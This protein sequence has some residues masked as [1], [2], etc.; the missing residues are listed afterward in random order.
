[1]KIASWNVNSVKARLEHLLRWLK[2]ASPDIVLLQELKCI[3]DKFPALEIGDAGYNVVVS[4]QKTYNG[5]A[6]LSKFPIDLELTALPGDETDEQARYIEAFSGGVRVGC[7]YLPN[8]NPIPGEKFDYK[9]DWMERLYAHTQSLLNNDEAF[10]LGGD[11]NVIPE[12]GD[13]YD[14]KMFATDALFQP[15]SRAA[16]RKIINLGLTDAF[17]ATTPETGLYTWWGYQA[18]GWPKDHGV[19]IDHLLLNP[20]AAD[21]LD[22]CGIDRTPRGW[23]KP[24]D[25]TP[26]WCSL[27]E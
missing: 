14:P 23:E 8:G 26:I 7:I 5:V 4:G 13:V 6:I 19:R 10:V 1:M 2:E 11:Y 15:E 27:R 24:S 12:D 16:L 22:G 25:H 9:L 21:R 20:Q 17:R 18:G 3:E